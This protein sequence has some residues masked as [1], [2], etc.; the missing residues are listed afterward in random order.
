GATTAI[1][2]TNW[3]GGQ[4]RKIVERA[5][6]AAWSPDGEQ[7]VFNAGALENSRSTLIG[8]AD[9]QD[10]TSRELV[11]IDNSVVTGPRWSPDGE[12][13]AAIAQP[14][15][16]NAVDSKLLLVD[17]ATGAARRLEP[18]EPA[19]HM[20]PP[21]WLGRG[22]ALVYALSTEPVGDAAGGLS[23]VV[24]YDLEADRHRTLFWTE[25]L[26]PTLGG[27]GGQT[28]FEV[29]GPGRLVYH[30]FAVRQTLE[31]YEIAG[32]GSPPD[33]RS[34]T[35]GN[36]DDR[37]PAYSPD[38]SAILFTSNRGGNLD[39]WLYEVESGAIRQLTDDDANDWDPGWTPDGQGIVWSSNRSGNLE[40]WTAARDGSGARQ[41][42]SDG[43][44][45]ENPTVTPDGWVVY[46]SS[47]PDKLG[48]WKVRLDGSESVH[49]VDGRYLTPDVSP[50]G[51]YA[52][53]L[54]LGAYETVIRVIE[55][56]TGEIVP[57]EITVSHGSG[58]GVLWGR[59]RWLPEG[60]AIAFVGVDDE[61]R[62][63]VFRQQFAPGRDTASTRRPLAGF[64][65]DFVTESF[66][67]DPS[68]R[69]LTLSGVRQV[70]SLLLVEGLPGI[71]P[72][73]RVGR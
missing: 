73:V 32:S 41:V 42:S 39:I 57:F 2:R 10:G 13:I 65:P 62:S 1:Y 51:R 4:P 8:I 29:V 44:D 54:S 34:L 70:G 3:V 12:T 58:A 25:N 68:G 60:D 19:A 52:T 45:A 23:R 27:G 40:I 5:L 43:F 24:R 72:P 30:E 9:A 69:Y 38:G 20:S 53:I 18:I 63:G 7:I 64:S 71:E 21:T 48:V 17:V 11:R 16:G 61:G 37:Q 66:T 46:W 35:A 59:T 28:Q 49:L 56:A 22:E 50:D 14:I 47:N 15:A 67:I 33:R 6:D 31:L 26:F 55:V 36:S